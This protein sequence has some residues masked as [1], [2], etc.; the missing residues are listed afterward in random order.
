VRNQEISGTAN[1]VVVQKYWAFRVACH[2]TISDL[3]NFSIHDVRSLAHSVR[4]DLAHSN[5]FFLLL[6]QKNFDVFFFELI[7]LLPRTLVFTEPYHDA[8]TF[9]L[10]YELVLLLET[11]STIEMTTSSMD[12]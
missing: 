3:Y 10:F 6:F 7:S 2:L 4:L 12:G 1:I 11:P 5:T 8:E 9:S